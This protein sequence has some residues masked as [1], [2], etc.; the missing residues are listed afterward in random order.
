M[1][2]TLRAKLQQG[3]PALGTFVQL[4]GTTIIECLALPGLDYVVLDLEHGTGS[5]AEAAAQILAAER[6]H[7]TPLVRIKDAS[8]ASVM[9]LLDQG[10][11]GLV[12][13]AIKTVEEVRDV[14]RYGKY[15]PLG[16]RGFGPSRTSAF[17]YSPDL[18]DLPQYLENCNRET[19]ILPQCETRECLEN[20]EE[21]VNLAGVDGLFIGPFDL[22]IALGIPAQFESDVM[23]AAVQ[24]ILSACQAAGKFCFIYADRTRARQRFAQ[25]FHSVATSMDT[26]EV[27]RAFQLLVRDVL[28]SK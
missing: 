16:E 22:S 3:E 17:T 1:H 4:G 8:R 6:H 18:Q 19:L 7:L 24:R 20:V 12:I 15:A 25:G 21:I 28:E 13:P 14:V 5:V 9:S 2:N 26:V 27:T 11:Q 10:A 23:Q